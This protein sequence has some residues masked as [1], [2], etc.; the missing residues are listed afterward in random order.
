MH[1]GTTCGIEGVVAL[2]F[3][4]RSDGSGGLVFFR[5]SPNKIFRSDLVNMVFT[6]IVEEMGTVVGLVK[7]GWITG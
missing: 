6:G 5:S 1:C 3:S 4:V 7:V 2:C